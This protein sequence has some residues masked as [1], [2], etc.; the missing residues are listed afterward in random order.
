MGAVGATVGA[1][2]GATVGTT[3]GATEG[4]TEGAVV[5]ASTPLNNNPHKPITKIIRTIFKSLETN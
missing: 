5:D 4:A 3:D 2:E 1:T